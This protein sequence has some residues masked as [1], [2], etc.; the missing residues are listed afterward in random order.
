MVSGEKNLPVTFDPKTGDNLVWSVELGTET[1]ATPVI[2]RGRVLIGT[3][4]NHPRDPR[5]QGDRGVL[6]C[7][8]EKDGRFL[9]QLVV[10]EIPGDKY[11]DRPN[12]EQQPCAH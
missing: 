1:P 7:F 6:M 4:N 12:A 8:D 5:H 2:A 10:P 11:L 9:W 3:N